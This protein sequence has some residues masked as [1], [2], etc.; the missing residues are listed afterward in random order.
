MHPPAASAD[1]AAWILEIPTRVMGFVME[2][3]HN[4]SLRARSL[5]SLLHQPECFIASVRISIQAMHKYF[6]KTPK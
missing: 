4:T 3:M 1:A 6:S 2:V 5:L